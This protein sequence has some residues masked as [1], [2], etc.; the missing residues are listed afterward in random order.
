MMTN[1]S[2]C[3]LPSQRFAFKEKNIVFERGV[4]NKTALLI[5]NYEKIIHEGI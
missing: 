1:L 3:K 5:V 2:I 4:K